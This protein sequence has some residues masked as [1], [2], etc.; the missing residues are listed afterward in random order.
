MAKSD[1]KETGKEAAYKTAV[2]EIKKNYG[3]ESI[4]SMDD[5]ATR[6]MEVE[7][8]STGC[9]SLDKVLGGGLPRGR[10]IEIY[11]APSSGKSVL[12][13]YLMAQLQKL[14]EKAVLIDAE[15]AFSPAF[16]EKIGLKVKDM[17]VCQPSTAEEALE[18]VRLLAESSSVGI[19]V[20]DSVASLVP[21]AELEGK[22]DEKQV[23]PLAS[24]MSK[25]LRVLTNSI[26]KSKTVVI[27]INQIRDK[28]SFF[29]SYGPK[30]VSSGGI[31]LKFYSSVRLE[32]RKGKN[33]T[34]N[35]ETKGEVIGNFISISAVKNKI[36]PPFKNC[37][38]E[39]LYERG[40]DIV[41]DL[42]DTAL[43]DEILTR[44]GNTISYG[45]VKLGVGREQAKKF[46][47]D[48]ENKKIYKEIYGSVTNSKKS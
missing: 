36:A 8:V 17:D 41:A 27:F 2:Q 43:K 9:L 46:L 3:S 24:L 39:L 29:P 47:A 30:T 32:V 42:L 34:L 13:I 5:E 18:I 19:V 11:G 35:D 15:C 48:E 10:V 16:A 12:S 1:N 20:V 40:V 7:F 23:A 22:L 26:S 21:R 33:I 45:E 37:E 6:K 44:S 31:A 38:V 14:G 28:I 25:S 4:I